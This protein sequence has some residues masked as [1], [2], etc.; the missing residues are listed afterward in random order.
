MRILAFILV[1]FLGGCV[2]VPPPSLS[3]GDLQR[4]RLVD[5]AVE[6]VAVIRS[7]PTQETA[8]LE[9]GAIAPDLKVRLDTE[10]ASNFP[11]VT[12]HFQRV[13]ADRSRAELARHVGPILS[14]PRPVRAVV[15]L[16]TFDIP[17][18]ARRVFVD[19]TAKIQADIDLVDAS[20]GATLL[21]YEGPLRTR[22]MVGGLA[23]GIALALDRSDVGV[24]M[25]DDYLIAYQNWLIQS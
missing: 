2:S 9:T 4:Y 23:T 3:V 22:P 10:P 8:L 14:G 18:A 21:R 15:R 24:A 20:T 1:L 6:N 13:L 7:W 19:N 25:L 12:A 11:Q 5:V 16:K 17:S